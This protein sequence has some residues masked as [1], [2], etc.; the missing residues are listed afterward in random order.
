MHIAMHCKH[1]HSMKK[2]ILL[3][4]GAI[5]LSICNI[6]AQKRKKT[7]M[8]IQE[9]EKRK[10]EYVQKK[11]KLTDSEAAKYFPIST[12]LSRKKFELHRERRRE[13]HAIKKNNKLT[14]KEY[15]QL[16]DNKID[17]KLKEAELDKEYTERLNKV[18]SPE[19]VFK[20]QQAEKEF[21]ENEVT[22]F[23]E[24]KRNQQK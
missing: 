22:K 3:L 6:Q 20:A 9:F 14:D 18:L 15:Q 10:Q 2:Y 12:E 8:D 13:M 19:K 17:I 11:A 16:I 21:I 7:V 24:Q 4:V 1:T 23:K 5:L